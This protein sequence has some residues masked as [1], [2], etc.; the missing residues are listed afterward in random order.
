MKKEKEKKRS[1]FENNL[2]NF[3][4]FIENKKKRFG[5]GHPN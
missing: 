4:P 1:Q 3:W 5:L 2:C